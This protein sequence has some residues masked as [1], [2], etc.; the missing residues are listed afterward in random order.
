M[1][2]LREYNAAL[3]TAIEEQS[4]SVHQITRAITAAATQTQNMAEGVQAL[5]RLAH[6]D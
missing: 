4:G 6:Q 5:G 3:A 1:A 2:E